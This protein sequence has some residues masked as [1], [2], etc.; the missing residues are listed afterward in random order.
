[1]QLFFNYK[2]ALSPTYMYV[3]YMYTCM[4]DCYPIYKPMNYYTN[5]IQE[6]K[7]LDSDWLRQLVQ[8]KCNTC[9]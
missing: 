8:F 4:L 1:M 2:N 9:I 6:K 3:T 7:L 5:N